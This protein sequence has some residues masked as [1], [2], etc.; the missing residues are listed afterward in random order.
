MPRVTLERNG[1]FAHCRPNQVAAVANQLKSGNADR[2][3]FEQN[4]SCF[5]D[6]KVGLEAT[7]R[8]SST[9]PTE[10]VCFNWRGGR[11]QII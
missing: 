11:R 6:I 9:D 1:I 10:M 8:H 5:S 7:V 4:N 2:D 3:G